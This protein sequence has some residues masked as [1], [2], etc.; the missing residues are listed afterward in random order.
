MLVTLGGERAK[1]LDN[2]G[3]KDFLNCYQ[4]AVISSRTFGQQALGTSRKYSYYK[5]K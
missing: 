4:E 3:H 2:F 5:Q 1:S